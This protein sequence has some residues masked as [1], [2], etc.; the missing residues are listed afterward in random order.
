MRTDVR[1]R[2]DER[3]SYKKEDGSVSHW[4]SLWCQTVGLLL[5]K[6]TG[7]DEETCLNQHRLTSDEETTPGNERADVRQVEV[8]SSTEFVGGCSLISDV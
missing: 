6:S 5:L 2:A 1:W 7:D 4:I 3:G 8:C